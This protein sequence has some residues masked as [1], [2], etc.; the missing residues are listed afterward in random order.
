VT[1]DLNRRGSSSHFLLA[2]EYISRLVSLASTDDLILLDLEGRK[3]SSKGR[4]VVDH[5]TG[6][7][8]D[9][10]TTTSVRR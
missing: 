5:F 10:R 2:T 7:K 6:S 9:G 8:D 1:H 3:D 4:Q